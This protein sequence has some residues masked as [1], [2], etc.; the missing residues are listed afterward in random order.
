MARVAII[1]D[2]LVV[3]F[4]GWDRVWCAE[5]QIVVPLASVKDAYV[6][7]ELKSETPWIAAGRTDE[8]LD[9][10]VAAGPMY[11]QGRREFWDV[12]H[13]E[14]AIVIELTGE[15][16]TRLVIEVGDPE[17]TV[18]AINEAVS[19]LEVPELPAAPAGPTTS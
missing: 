17:G 16:Y 8:L 5:R 10:A 19:E 9:Y 2:R 15:H 12:H 7:L 1:K 13:P 6:D 14:R 11:V 3:E 4:E 18:D